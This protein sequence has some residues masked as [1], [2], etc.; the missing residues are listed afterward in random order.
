[1]A[2][3]LG[4]EAATRPVEVRG[5]IHDAICIVRFGV[6]LMPLPPAMALPAMIDATL[7]AR[8]AEQTTSS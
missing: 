7:R 5:T 4:D 2:L 6:A 1:L 8:Q 3:R